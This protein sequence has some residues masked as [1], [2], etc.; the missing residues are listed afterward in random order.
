MKI[1]ITAQE[2]IDKGIWK[3]VADLKRINEYAMAEV[4]DVN[5]E[6]ELSMDEAVELGLMLLPSN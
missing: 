1:I 3:E 4:M 6:I 5:T 2:C